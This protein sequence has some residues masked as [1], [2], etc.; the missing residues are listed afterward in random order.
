MEMSA[1][2]VHISATTKLCMC[3][4]LHVC[5]STKFKKLQNDHNPPPQIYADLPSV[6]PGLH[7][8]ENDCPLGGSGRHKEVEPNAAE[9]I[10]DEK[11]A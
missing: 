1:E 9:T 3:P 8:V 5:I 4:L 10:S 7:S 2:A 11:G 6:V